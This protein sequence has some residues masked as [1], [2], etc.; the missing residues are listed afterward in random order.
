M[1]KTFIFFI[2]IMSYKSLEPL[3]PAVLSSAVV[4]AAKV[5]SLKSIANFSDYLHWLIVQIIT[6]LKADSSYDSKLY[7]CLKRLEI[8]SEESL[9]CSPSEKLRT[10]YIYTAYQSSE[11]DGNLGYP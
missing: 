7:D 3:P 11:G 1:W 10:W 2:N 6:G 8:S 9:E 5:N 4:N